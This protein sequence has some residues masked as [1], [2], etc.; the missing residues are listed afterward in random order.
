MRHFTLTR[1]NIQGGRE[2]GRRG[3][4][5]RG[6]DREWVKGW[7]HRPEHPGLGS[8]PGPP[9]W[10]LGLGLPR[11]V[12]VGSGRESWGEVPPVLDCPLSLGARQVILLPPQS[13]GVKPEGQAIVQRGHLGQRSRCDGAG[14]LTSQDNKGRRSSDT[15]PQQGLKVVSHSIN[16]HYGDPQRQ[17]VA[18]PVTTPLL[19]GFAPRAQLAPPRGFP[20][21]AGCLGQRA[22]GWQRTGLTVRCQEQWVLGE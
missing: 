1:L 2:G 6:R 15:E 16:R 17:T 5:G 10:G 9:L 3:G 13:I 4:R 22:R 11:W 21:S 12:T 20:S 14:G 18:S 19:E 8:L 7:G